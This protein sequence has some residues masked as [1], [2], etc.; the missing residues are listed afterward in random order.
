MLPS[1]HPFG[2]PLSP[3]LCLY[4]LL[5]STTIPPVCLQRIARPDVPS[6]PL[7]K[8]KMPVPSL[9]LFER[10]LN[11]FAAVSRLK[12]PIGLLERAWICTR[13]NNTLRFASDQANRSFQSPHDSSI[14]ARWALGFGLCRINSPKSYSMPIKNVSMKPSGRSIDILWIPITLASRI[15]SASS[16]NLQLTLNVCVLIKNLCSLNFLYRI[17]LNLD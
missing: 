12:N 14:S 16:W 10:L 6:S 17:L 3:T 7:L 9:N 4:H 15:F 8:T 13:W 2:M 1:S 11:D 5:L